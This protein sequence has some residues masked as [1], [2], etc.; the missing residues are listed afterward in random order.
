MI[1]EHP[2]KQNVKSYDTLIVQ[3]VSDIKNIKLYKFAFSSVG[4]IAMN[5]SNK[6]VHT[7][8]EWKL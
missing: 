3:T 8:R 4:G 5:K 2:L 6:L 7:R 1:K